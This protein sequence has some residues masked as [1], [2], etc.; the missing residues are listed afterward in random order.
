MGQPSKTPQRKYLLSILHTNR[1]SAPTH[2]TKPHLQQH[3]LIKYYITNTHRPKTNNH[4][5][6][7]LYLT[8]MH[9]SLYDK[10]TPIWPTP[11]TSQSPCRSPHC[12]INSSCRST[13][14]TRWLWHNTTYSHPQPLNRI[15][16][17]PIPH[18]IL[19]RHNHNKPNMPPTNRSKITYRILF[20]K[21]HSPCN[22]SLPH[23]NPLKLFR[24]NHPHDC[25]RTHLFHIFLPSQF[26]LRTHSQPY[27]TTVPRTSNPTSTNSLLM[28]NSKPY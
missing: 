19:V 23:P 5:I 28:I 1:L 18:T 11:V 17:L 2:H 8:S 4:L 7:Q 13:P 16:S 6:S 9:N 12:R 25:S 22:C 24:R 20:C 10:N 27:Y 21:S 15:H 3:R 14:K 26:K